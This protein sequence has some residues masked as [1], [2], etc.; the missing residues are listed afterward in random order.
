MSIFF[1]C[2]TGQLVVFIL[3]Y[4]RALIFDV[5]Q[6]QGNLIVGTETLPIIIG[7]RK[8][9]TFIRILL[10]FLASILL[11]AGLSKIFPYFSYIML[12]PIFGLFLC[13][14]AYEKKWL[15]LS[16]YSEMLVELNFL[17][18]GALAAIITSYGL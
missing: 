5:F 11:I 13:T 18:T 3:S 2:Y 16:I 7:E 4:V 14:V 8:A 9:L 17:I 12:I 6:I 10:I 15:Y 1:I